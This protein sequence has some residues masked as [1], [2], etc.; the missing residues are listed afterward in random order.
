MTDAAVERLADDQ[1]ARLRRSVDPEALE[2]LLARL[3]KAERALVLLG[4]YAE[5]TAAE[6]L[7]ALR[8]AGTSE[9]ELDELR[10]FAEYVPLSPHLA[11]RENDLDPDWIAPTWFVHLALER[12]SEQEI[13]V[14][15]EAAEPSRGEEAG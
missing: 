9:R 5:P 14:L 13:G 3:P 8:A 10:P 12:P 11:H 15:W 6:T 1:R 7:E 4:F 2:R